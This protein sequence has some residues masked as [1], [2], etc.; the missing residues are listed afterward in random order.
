MRDDVRCSEEFFRCKQFQ[1]ERNWSFLFGM[2]CENKND[3][4]AAIVVVV[5]VFAVIAVYNAIRHMQT[6]IWAARSARMTMCVCVCRNR[7][8]TAIQHKRLRVRNRVANI[9]KHSV[10]ADKQVERARKTLS[11]APTSSSI[12]PKKMNEHRGHAL[13]ET[14]EATG[15][16]ENGESLATVL[17]TSIE[18]WS[19]R[20]ILTTGASA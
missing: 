7:S 16:E 10:R 17:A 2:K 13:W 8:L 11:V 12:D 1:W 6:D 15:N 14:N 5:A 3:L 19:S 9:N 20:Y 4:I 18:L